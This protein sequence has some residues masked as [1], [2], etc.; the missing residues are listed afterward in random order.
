MRVLFLVLSFIIKEGYG[1]FGES[2]E[3]DYKDD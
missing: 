3:E 1:E 2:L